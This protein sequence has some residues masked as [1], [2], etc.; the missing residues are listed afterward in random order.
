MNTNTSTTPAYADLSR[1]HQRLYR[2]GHLQAIASWDQSAFMPAKGNESRAA[3][4]AE[5]G[6]LMHELATAPE[7]KALLNQA[8]AE[9]LGDFERASLREIDELVWTAGT[10][11]V[12][13]R[14][15]V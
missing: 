8:S 2:L 11:V 4:L 6:G 7:L 9:P 15:A 12:A 10:R 13:S 5:M 14:R 1:R 3:A